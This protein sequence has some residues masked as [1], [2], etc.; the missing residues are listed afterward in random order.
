MTQVDKEIGV[1][2]RDLDIADPG[3]LQAGGIDETAGKVSRG[4]SGVSAD[5]PRR[6]RLIMALYP[7]PFRIRAK[8][9]SEDEMLSSEEVGIECV[10]NIDAAATSKRAQFYRL[11]ANA[12]RGV[13]HNG[14]P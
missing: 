4:S 10:R 2:R 14:R 5:R 8:S 13:F 9:S 3:S 1:E 7:A 11:S 12:E 6:R